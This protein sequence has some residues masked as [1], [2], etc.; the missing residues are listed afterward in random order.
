[1]VT[2]TGPAWQR[3]PFLLP[4]LLAL[5]S[6][7]AAGLWRLG[8]WSTATVPPVLAQ[9][10]AG[11]GALMVCGFFGVV[12]SVE[13]AVALGADGR[14]RRWAWAAPLAAGAGSLLVLAG[15]PGLAG[16]AWLLASMVLLLTT[17]WVWQRQREPFVGVLALGACAWTVGSAQWLSGAGVASAVPWWLAFLVY[18]IAGERLELS[19]LAPRPRSA[20]ISFAL[21][22]VLL[23]AAL[24]AQLAGAPLRELAAPV[25]GAGL[26][27]LAAWLLRHDLARRT[28]RQQG[29]ARYIA[30]SLLAGYGWLALGGAV[31]MVTGLQP[32]TAGWDAALHAILLGFVFSMVYGHAPIILPAVLRVSLAYG[33][34]FYAPLVLLHLAVAG[35]F[36]GS[37]LGLDDL[38]RASAWMSALALLLF[39]A[40]LLWAAR[41]RRGA[42]RSTRASGRASSRAR[43]SAASAGSR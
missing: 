4:G 24:L 26:L 34:R 9:A 5:L 1:M 42:A 37:L 6:G 31:I 3:L 13:R 32:G 8:A 30:C 43:T 40:T 22:M 33:P 39:V 12:I 27:A 23:A 11:H 18:T 19:R 14:P 15:A 7:V 20:E 16:W 21:L 38:R 29:L 25:F 10:A 36:G 2:S 35:R 28:V 17:V 41:A